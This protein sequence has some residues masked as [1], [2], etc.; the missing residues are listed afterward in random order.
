MRRQLCG[1]AM[2]CFAAVTL[3]K[4][5]AQPFPRDE[6]GH[7]RF[8]GVVQVEGAGAAELYGRAKLWA[9]KAFVSAKDVVQ[10]DDPAGGRL[11]LKGTHDEAYGLTER[12]WFHLTLTVEVK[13]GR[14]RWTLDQLEY[15]PQGKQG[16]PIERELTKEGVGVFGRK[17]AFERFRKALL[18]LASNLQVAMT[19]QGTTNDKW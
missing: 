10:L 7:V 15:S 5:E 18:A 16:W 1:V 11:I 3:A 2:I 14:Y 9:A 4:D 8:Q 13:D 6:A 12:V 19:T 17:A